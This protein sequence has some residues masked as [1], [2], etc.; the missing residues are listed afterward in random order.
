MNIFAKIREKRA[1]K[2]QLRRFGQFANV[3]ASLQR[4]EKSGLLAWEAKSRRLF[5]AQPLAVVMLAQG[6]DRWRN[7][8]NN[9]FLYHM[10]NLQNRQWQDHIINEQA[11]A[12]RQRKKEVVVLTKAETERI[13]RA[14]RDNIPAEA[15]E[16]PPIKPS[17]FFIIADTA[18]VTDASPSEQPKA[19]ITWVG[20]YD[21]DTGTL[22][23]AEW[24]DIKHVIKDGNK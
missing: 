7:F 11:K 3:F 24:K 2:A 19:E 9:V 6:Y 8:L 14:V 15:V 21:P 16:L 23:M 18:T 10:Y 22:D 1:Q 5:I 17:E 4:L 13:R 12:V 20:E